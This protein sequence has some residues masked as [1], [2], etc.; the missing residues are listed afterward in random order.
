MGLG[1]A[2][3]AS[4]TRRACGRPTRVPHPTPP[5]PQ[6]QTLHLQHERVLPDDRL[7]AAVVAVERLA[8][9]VGVGV[10]VH[11]DLQVVGADEE[12]VLGV[13]VGVGAGAG[14][15]GGVSRTSRRAG[16]CCATL[17]SACRTAPSGPA[18]L[19]RGARR[20]HIPHLRAREHGLLVVVDQQL[21]FRAAERRRLGPLL[22]VGDARDHLEPLARRAAV[23]LAAVGDKA[24]EQAER[25]GVLDARRVEVLGQREVVDDALARPIAGTEEAC[26]VLRQLHVEDEQRR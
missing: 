8:R 19:P 4:C 1:L 7:E 9:E 10:D 25:G 5:P 16:V 6:P 21:V 14:G 2:A 13:G 22:R 17:A 23:G 18:A 26:G 15:G 24:R 20:G 12:E 3:A 11:V